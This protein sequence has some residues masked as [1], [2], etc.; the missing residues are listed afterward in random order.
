MSAS[1]KELQKA[2]LRYTA[3]TLIHIHTVRGFCERVPKWMLGRESEL[4][5][6]MDIKDRADGID[7]NISHVSQSEN[8]GEAFLEYMKSKVTQV[9][10]KSRLEELEKELAAVLKDTLMELEKLHCFL[11]AVEKL[12]VTSLHVFVEGRQVVL[13]LPEGVGLDHVQ[14]VIAAA[15]LVCP[16]LVEFKRD[17]MVFFQPKLQNVEVLAYQLDKYIQTTQRICGLLEKST[18]SDFDLN[19]I[20]KSAVDLDLD[21]SE[22]DMERMLYHINQLD[23]I[24]M[25]QHFSLVY[26]FHDCSG[27]LDEFRDCQPRLL[28]SLDGLEEIAVQFDSMNKGA[29][30]SSVVGSSVG[31]VGGVL[32]I[33]GLALIPV[34]AGVSLGLTMTGIGLSVTSG[35]NGLVTTATELG[36]NST[37]QKKAAE[38][39][40]G[41]MKDLQSLQ[42]CLKKVSNQTVA[43]MEASQIDVALGVSR[44]LVKG[45][46]IARG[47]DSLVDTASAFK[48]LKNEELVVSAGKVL[49]EEGQALR[50]VPKVAAD[51]PDIGQAAIKGPLALTKSARVGL[52]GL[53]A[54]F[55]GM[56]VFFIC[57]D[58]ISLS[59]GSETEASQFIRARAAL[60]RS[61]IDAWQKIYDS[62]TE[63][64]QK[65]EKNKAILETPFH[66]ELESELKMEMEMEMKKQ[67]QTEMEIPPDEENEN[68]EKEGKNC[69]IQ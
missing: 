49:A 50:N 24:R 48:M 29:K 35:V 27:F 43:R 3:D 53:N 16:L 67:K 18:F 34:T 1:R 22:D 5:M 14:V 15:R 2:L 61:E 37:Q 30:I 66:P 38:V 58:S 62:L 13:H 25:N 56:D 8:K 52:I 42:D 55:L 28:Q 51:I 63:G 45:G 26:L 47:V 65:S 23:D 21:L 10:A 36:V 6:M 59:K 40:E 69:V 60:W 33:I 31:A 39:F 9:T 11:D 64:L 20:K 57:K 54:L 32:S 19:M 12:A 41:L 7:L 17:E 46:F 44:V 68:M 4:N